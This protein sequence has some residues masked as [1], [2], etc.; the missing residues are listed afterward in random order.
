M[1][2][3]IALASKVLLRGRK[4]LLLLLL[5]RS[6][7]NVFNYFKMQIHTL[8]LKR[9]NQ[10]INNQTVIK[11]VYITT[12]S[13]LNTVPRTE[14]LLHKCQLIKQHTTNL[15]HVLFIAIIFCFATCHSESLKHVK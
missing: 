14:Q 11:G 9:I 3:A 13:V 6:D 8:F 7:L 5:H 10:P 4:V 12:D 1:E 15:P 2:P